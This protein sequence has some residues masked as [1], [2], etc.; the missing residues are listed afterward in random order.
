M[1]DKIIAA[2]RNMFQDDMTTAE[3]SAALDKKARGT[4]GLSW[5]TS[6]VDLMKVLELDNSM[7]ARRQLALELGYTKSFEGT[8]ADNEWLH[9]RVLAEVVKHGIK[10][11]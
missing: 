1:F 11:P 4:K 7:S 9:E 10:I 3:M 5:R 8:A 2:L 6:T